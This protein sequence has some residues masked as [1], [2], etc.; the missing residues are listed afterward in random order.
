MANV[1][2]RGFLSGCVGVGA[3]AGMSAITPIVWQ[4]VLLAAKD[5]PLRPGK[6]ILVIITLYGG[7][8]GL[9]TVIP[10][11]DSS[12]YDARREIAYEAD[13]V[14]PL[15]ESY[16]LNPGMTGMLDMF[17]RGSLAIVR[18]VGYPK[19]D[20][21]HFRS[22]DIWQ[23]ASTDNSVTSGWIARWLAATGGDPLAALHMGSV[24]PPLATGETCSASAFVSGNRPS[25]QTM[26]LIEALAARDSVDSEAMARVCESY[27]ATSRTYRDLSPLF[28]LD[29]QPRVELDASLTSQLDVVA[30]CV[31]AGVPS[32]V[33][34]VG[35][36]G[37]D[38]HADEKETQQNL[39]QNLD[40]SV[41]R[42]MSRIRESDHGRDV[43]V[44]AYSEFGRRV[45][46]NASDGTD[47]GTA[48]PVF[49]LGDKV[50]G[51]FYGEDPSLKKLVDDD[52]SVTTDFRDIYHELLVRVLDSDPEPVIGGDRHEIGVISA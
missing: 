52:L 20:R 14:L 10:F 34:S 31:N 17:Q 29:G 32:N 37:F 15:N 27:G 43:V 41:S 18:G 45:R 11:Q 5:R 24:L 33:Y 38:T 50:Q 19:S 44:M 8:D 35:L 40:H 26:S 23:T 46:A 48:G 51:G 4:D 16:G 47:H 49:L 42:F 9:N 6:G 25:R 28:A 21:S 39:L 12:Y 30:A 7:N 36:G 2:R 13:E 1:S 22:M 3:I